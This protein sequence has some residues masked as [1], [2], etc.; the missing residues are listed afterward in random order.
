MCFPPK[1]VKGNEMTLAG[2]PMIRDIIWNNG[3]VS[4]IDFEVSS[5]SQNVHWKK[6]R[7]IILFVYGFCRCVEM[8]IP[9]Q[10]QTTLSTLQAE[11]E[12]QLWNDAIKFEQRLKFVYAILLPFRKITGADSRGFYGLIENLK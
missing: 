11:I 5:K 6:V 9:S 10:I 7:D 3:D 2:R 1:R 8:I 12:L 4:F